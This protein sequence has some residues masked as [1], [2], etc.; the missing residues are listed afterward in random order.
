MKFIIRHEIRGRIRVQACV[1]RMSIE[2][3]DTLQYYLDTRDFVTS[4][5]IQRNTLSIVIYYTGDRQQVLTA[6]RNF[7]YENV[8]VPQAVFQSSGR[9]LNEE[10]W[11]KLVNSVIMRAGS[12]LFLP[13]PIRAGIAFVKSWKYLW[14][15]AKT[16]AQGK[17][18]VPVLDA[19]AIGVSVFRGDFDTAGS[20]MFL[21]GVGSAYPS[22]L[23]S[24]FPCF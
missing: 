22:R 12:K 6:L 18:E 1:R 17:M 19:T 14:E 3:A 21:L 8:N 11:E 7:R 20:V 23:F 5:K 24:G 16:L 4:A 13:Y 2:E 9:A 10:Y 15:G